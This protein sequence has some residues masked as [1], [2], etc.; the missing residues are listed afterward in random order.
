MENQNGL[1]IHAVGSCS[2][3]RRR[4]VEIEWINER[5]DGEMGKEGRGKETALLNEGACEEGERA[6]DLSSESSKLHSGD[7]S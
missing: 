2:K 1:S 5:G 4:R 7:S 3:K 6:V